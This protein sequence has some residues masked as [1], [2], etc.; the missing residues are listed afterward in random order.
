L[1]TPAALAAL[2][3]VGIRSNVSFTV[4]IVAPL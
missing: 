1:L 3:L 4:G 2:N